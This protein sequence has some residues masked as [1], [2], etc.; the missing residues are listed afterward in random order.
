M[1]GLS[2]RLAIRIDGNHPMNNRRT[3]PVSKLERKA[4]EAK[5]PLTLLEEY[6][7]DLGHYWQ[8][9]ALLHSMCR[10]GREVVDDCRSSL[11]LWT[12]SLTC[13]IPSRPQF[14]FWSVYRRKGPF[15]SPFPHVCHFWSG[16]PFGR[17]NLLGDA[18]HLYAVYLGSQN[19]R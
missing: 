2:L 1:N 14:V 11:G 9:L 15:P 13:R 8:F 18:A 7:V 16:N 3:S 10:Q 12:S 6:D 19:V 5:R 17:R 4:A